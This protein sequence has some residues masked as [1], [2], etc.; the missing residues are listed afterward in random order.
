MS[1]DC[2]KHLL[3]QPYAAWE[4]G[5]DLWCSPLRRDS[6]NVGRDSGNVGR[7]SRNVGRDTGNVSRALGNLGLRR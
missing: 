2:D 5:D 1:P 6:G 7:S 3:L 4:S